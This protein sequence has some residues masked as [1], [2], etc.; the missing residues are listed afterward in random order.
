[1]S[2]TVVSISV[3]FAWMAA[4]QASPPAP[5]QVPLPEPAR[6]EEPLAPTVRITGTAVAVDSLGVEHAQ[7][8][9]LVRALQWPAGVIEIPVHEGRFE[10]FVRADA[11]I[12]NAS[13]T[14]AGRSVR[15]EEQSIPADA[16]RPLELHGKWISDIVLHVIDATSRSELK[17]CEWVFGSGLFGVVDLDESRLRDGWS[18]KGVA[19]PLHLT[20][21]GRYW[22]R[23]PGHAWG[24]IRTSNRP[25]AWET[26]LELPA[27]CCVIVQLAERTEPGRRWLAFGSSTE[28]DWITIDASASGPL[29][30]DSLPPGD[31][32]LRTVE[33]FHLKPWIWHDVTLAST[34]ATLQAG[35]AAT[36][37]LPHESLPVGLQED[38]T[39]DRT[40][41][42]SIAGGKHDDA[43][44]RTGLIEFCYFHRGSTD[45]LHDAV[46]NTMPM[47][48][49]N[50][51]GIDPYRKFRCDVRDGRVKLRPPFGSV[52]GLSKVVL[53]GT[54]YEL[55]TECLGFDTVPE[56]FLIVIPDPET[57]GGPATILHVRAKG[58]ESDLDHVFVARFD[59]GH[60]T[61]GTSPFADHPGSVS[62]QAL[63][64]ANRRSPVTVRDR[65][66]RRSYPEKLYVRAEGFAWTSIRCDWR[67]GGEQ[68]V[69]LE[70]AS[71]LSI[72]LDPPIDA[73]GAQLRVFRTPGRERAVGDLRKD[74]LDLDGEPALGID[75]VPIRADLLKRIAD[76]EAGNEAE[77]LARHG[78]RPVFHGM[79]D[80]SGVTA[81]EALPCDLLDVAIFNGANDRTLLGAA[82]VDASR[83]GHY[84]V[85]IPVHPAA[86]RPRAPMAGTVFIPS[87]WGDVTWSLRVEP[88]GELTATIQ[89]R[90]KPPLQLVDS[91]DLKGR[92]FAWN[93]GMV[94]PGSY[95][96]VFEASHGVESNCDYFVRVDLGDSGRQD[97]RV[98]VP[99]PSWVQFDVVDASSGDPA[100]VDDVYWCF[101][102]TRGGVGLWTEFHSTRLSR[103]KTVR[104][105]APASRICVMIEDSKYAAF[106]QVFELSP[107][108]NRFTIRLTRACGI[109]LHLLEEATEIE[110]S[111]EIFV[112]VRTIA[113]DGTETGTTPELGNKIKLPAPGRYRLE[114]GTPVGSGL[115]APIDVTVPAGE[116][117]DVSVTR[118]AKTP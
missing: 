99:L 65:S 4:Q 50:R 101:D 38:G 71:D 102:P 111:P 69:D 100:N 83:G 89:G 34:T 90:L 93:A 115:I 96:F 78:S 5:A 48:E 84:A 41:I 56:P 2:P 105:Y 35:Q 7:E 21:E 62:A 59:G 88:I 18:A 81:I 73:S 32:K 114:F 47:G 82:L 95:Q 15:L 109:H 13:L 16:D 29:R 67:R 58:T 31:A 118:E 104:I 75:V 92:E 9:G 51:N 112:F 23:A 17:E 6:V 33:S 66:G 79:L 19:S 24:M 46:S 63:I 25:T 70:L 77:A 49:L 55:G 40:G 64:V 87:E 27:A 108:E 53:D 37:A 39:V 76:L 72:T 44:C 68:F 94:I 86:I 45:D 1:M 106:D 42:V 30:I 20:R 80:P 12:T 3:A 103:Q 28:S 107:G 117:I 11:K 74:L 85:V 26:T 36:V 10:A 57:V 22:V 91:I 52:L 54:E 116:F 14:L 98:E 61:D 97:L 110:W 113:P 60:R 8:D 43:R